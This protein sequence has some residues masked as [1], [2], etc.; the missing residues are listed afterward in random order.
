MSALESQL[1]ALIQ[2]EIPSLVQIRHEL[3]ENP[4]VNFQETY[5]SALVQR[6][7]GQ[8]GVAYRSG[9]GGGTGV[10]AHLPGAEA[11]AIGLRADIDALPIEEQNDFAYISKSP[12]VMHACGHDGHTTILIGVARVLAKIAKQRP[13]PRPVTFIFQP[14]EEV[15]AGADRM[16]A[17]GCLDGSLFAPPVRH[18]FALH[19]WPT[20]PQG[21]I[22]TR[23]GPMMAATYS[24]RVKITGKGC[25]AAFPHLG[26]DPLVAAAAIIT[27][28]QTIVA[29]NVDPLSAAVVSVTQ[30]HSGTT[31]NIIPGEVVLEGTIRALDKAVEELVIRRFHEIAQHIAAAHECV[32]EIEYPAPP[33]PVAINSAE[34][35]G[36]LKS[37]LP[38]TNTDMLPVM[39]GED[40]A[41]YSQK[42]PSAFFVLGLQSGPEKMAGL[43]HP[44]FDFN[45]QVIP[46]G[47]EAFCRLALRTAERD[48]R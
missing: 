9:L 31:F 48:A 27:A 45:D 42:V 34:A 16:I 17:D 20:L 32:A 21:Y 5:A 41:F 1:T 39:G 25:H 7:L 26:R 46:A 3:H 19:G 43:H 6:E 24:F 15:G 44:K 12:G 47:I 18:M 30:C 14:A 28:A 37:V 8:A 40:F 2:A 13:L 38:E 35:V 11:Q 36:V 23:V 29:R 10:V 33:Y 4:G 22:A